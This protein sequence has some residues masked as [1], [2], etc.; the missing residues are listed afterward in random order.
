MARKTAWRELQPI[1]CQSVCV[2]VGEGCRAAQACP[3][4]GDG[5]GRWG[6]VKC[7]R[8]AGEGGRYARYKRLPTAVLPKCSRGRCAQVWRC[9]QR[10]TYERP[11]LRACVASRAA[12][13]TLHTQPERSPACEWSTARESVAVGGAKQSAVEEASVRSTCNHPVW[14]RDSRMC[15]LDSWPSNHARERGFIV[16]LTP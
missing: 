11:R 13:H 2:R 12:L 1:P 15:S 10:K 7:S 14:Y 8:D 6:G 9:A 3:V 16:I 5:V 4:G